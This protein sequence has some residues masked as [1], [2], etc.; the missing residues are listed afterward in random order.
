MESAIWLT[1]GPGQMLIV[2]STWNV[3]S[4]MAERRSGEVSSDPGEHE[5]MKLTRHV[6]S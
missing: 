5:S 6:N 1:Y 3:L 2:S 4:L